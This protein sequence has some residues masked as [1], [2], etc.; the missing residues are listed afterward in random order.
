[1][2]L[3]AVLRRDR[4]I[5]AVALSGVIILSWLYVLAGAGMGMTALDM[6]RMSHP[7]GI[8]GEVPTGVQAGM[9]QFMTGPR[10]WSSAYAVL[11]FSM[12]WVM[13]LGMMLPSAAPMLLLYAQVMRKQRDKGAPYVSTGFFALGYVAMWAG[14]SIAAVVAQWALEDS[15]LLSAMMVGTSATLG[16]VLLILA[17]VWQLTP[18]KTACLRHCRSPISFLSQYWRGG[19]AGAVRM[20][21]LHGAYCLGCC[22]F[23]MALLFY[24]GVMNLYWII[25][26][27]V[28]VLVE[29]LLPVGAWFGRLTGVA[30][31][32]WGAALL[33]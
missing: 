18:L 32:G 7:V 11:M 28:F 20:G 22:W 9:A 5:V 16:A 30:L 15:G 24:G 33:L 26:L 23:L 13:M 8:A 2:G 21:L 25:G 19:A 27:A 1:M 31:I 17:G 29:K 14:F 4:L 10:S 3:E 12:W 6:T